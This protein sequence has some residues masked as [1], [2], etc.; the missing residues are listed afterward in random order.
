MAQSV[1]ENLAFIKDPNA[2]ALETTHRVRSNAPSFAFV[3]F[4]G[5]G[6]STLIGQLLSNLDGF[7]AK[8]KTGLNFVTY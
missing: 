4:S 2:F 8:E 5:S 6:R 1:S 7:T 3:G